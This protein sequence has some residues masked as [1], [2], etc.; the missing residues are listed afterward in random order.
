MDGVWCGRLSLVSLGYIFVTREFGVENIDEGLQISYNLCNLP[1]QITAANGTSV[2]YSY[3]A[4]GTKFKAVNAAGNGF[5]YTGSLRWSVHNGVLTPESVAITGGRALY[6]D[7]E[8]PWSANYYITDHLGSVRAVTDAEGEMLE[9]Y[10][11]LQMKKKHLNDR[12]ISEVYYFGNVIM[13][14]I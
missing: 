13:M 2:K 6:N 5:A 14:F 4:D 3:F 7:V 12:R 11:I 8:E 1:K 9:N 10:M